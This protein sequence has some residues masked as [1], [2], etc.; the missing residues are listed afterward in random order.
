MRLNKLSTISV[1]KIVRMK[2]FNRLTQHDYSL[3]ITW[4]A[5]IFFVLTFFTIAHATTNEF[6]IGK[7]YLIQEEDFLDWIQKRLNSLKNSPRWNDI[8]TTFQQNVI[9]RLYHPVSVVGVTKTIKPRQFEYDPTLVF[10]QT[11]TNDVGEVVVRAGT[12]VNP[13]DYVQLSHPLLFIDGNDQLQVEWALKQEK[14][15]NRIA[16]IILVSGSFIDLSEK[17]KRP[18]YF[19]QKGQ[20]T[21]KLHIEHVPAV[22]K[23]KGK[24]LVIEEQLP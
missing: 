18:V 10:P 13:L 22:V 15:L 8:N 19:D 17:L 16:K 4:A 20:L 6:I 1:D 2:C 21:K 12:K 5:I 9:Q 14:Q 24:V 3:R 11:L 23:Q 7:T